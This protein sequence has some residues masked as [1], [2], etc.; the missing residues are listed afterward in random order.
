MKWTPSKTDRGGP[1][2]DAAVGGLSVLKRDKVGVDNT[3]NAVDLSDI[4][5]SLSDVST[6]S[7]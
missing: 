5:N 4:E 2:E 6:S 1:A 3:L 7:A